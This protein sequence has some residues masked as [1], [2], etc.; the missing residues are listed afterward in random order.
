MQ[1]ISKYINLVW[2]EAFNV[3]RSADAQLYETKW[4]Q[5]NDTLVLPQY[6]LINKHTTEAFLFD[7]QDNSCKWCE[8]ENG[9]EHMGL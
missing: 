5:R 8:S 1:I 9:R 4:C 6:E 2:K 7:L 3:M